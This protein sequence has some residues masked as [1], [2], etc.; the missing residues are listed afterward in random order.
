VPERFL[1]Q[2]ATFLVR[3]PEI[4]HQLWQ[5]KVCPKKDKKS[6]C[7]LLRQAGC[8][9]RAEICPQVSVD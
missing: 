8:N 7:H 3:I 2:A 4:A 5:M 6:L 1:P 9:L